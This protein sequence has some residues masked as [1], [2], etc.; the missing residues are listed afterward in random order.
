MS[1]VEQ[2]GV[3]TQ[4]IARN[5]EQAASGTQE[6][7]SNI[8]QVTDVAGR[9]GE[10]AAEQLQAAEGVKDGIGQMNAR[11]LEIIRDSQDPEAA[12]RYDL[13]LAVKVTVSGV[14]KDTRLHTLSK[15]GGAVLDRGLEV[16]EGDLFTIELPEAGTF[17][18]SIVAKTD[19]HTHVRFDLDDAAAK[20]VADFLDGRA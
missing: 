19:E 9:S 14:V 7:S 13:G 3:A 16:R 17:D 4:E 11:L 2:Q 12:K 1:W 10:A 6:V 15:G 8:T 20:R 5:V 18:A